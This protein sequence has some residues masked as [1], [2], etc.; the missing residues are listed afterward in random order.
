MV[1]DEDDISPKSEMTTLFLL[2]FFG[3]FGAH[4]FYVHKFATGIFYLVAGSTTIVF[5]IFGLRWELIAKVLIIFINALDWYAL[6][7][8]SFTD[9]K[10]RLVIGKSKHLVYDSL[11]E[12]EKIIFTERLNTFMLVLVGIA[13][14]ILLI[15]VF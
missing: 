3:G 6:Y 15:F 7:S 8:D 12:R 1:Y 9:S 2:I 13:F 14:Y 10:G 4:R 5:K 11:E